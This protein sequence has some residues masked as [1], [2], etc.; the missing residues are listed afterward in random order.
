MTEDQ[1][2][3]S[4]ILDILNATRVPRT[5]AYIETEVKLAGRRCEIP[6]IL[7]TMTDKKLIE[8]AKDSL[9]IR[10]YTITPAGREALADL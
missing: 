10:R 2:A 1:K 4:L 9:D 8:S 3:I 6:T 5:L 7:E